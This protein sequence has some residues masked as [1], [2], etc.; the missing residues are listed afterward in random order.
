MYPWPFHSKVSS[1]SLCSLSPWHFYPLVLASQTASFILNLPPSLCLF[2]P[3][4]LFLLIAFSFL[5]SLSVFLSLSRLL[6]ALL[7]RKGRHRERDIKVHLEGARDTERA[8]VSQLQANP[9]R[10]SQKELKWQSEW[11]N[12]WMNEPVNFRCP[13]SQ[14][15]PENKWVTQPLSLFLPL[16]YSQTHR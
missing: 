3:V 4:S 11:V 7:F 15:N 13:S 6:S 8:N 2:V 16:F 14:L 9:E 1:L 5:F 12:E 10:R